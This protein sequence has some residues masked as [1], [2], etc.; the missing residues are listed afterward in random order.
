MTVQRLHSH[1]FHV[2][3]LNLCPLQASVY[4]YEKQRYSLLRHKSKWLVLQVNTTQTDSLNTSDTT[5]FI[6]TLDAG[7][8]DNVAV[9]II[10]HSSS[11]IK[12]GDVSIIDINTNT[13]PLLHVLTTTTTTTAAAA[14]V[15]ADA[16]TYTISTI[17]YFRCCCNY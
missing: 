10:Q 5:S 3:T 7:V 14:A 15:P 2:K 12:I 9:V 16:S 1:R 11:E 13:S 17:L 4:A 6:H 8:L